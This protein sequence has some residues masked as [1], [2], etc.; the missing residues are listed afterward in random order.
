MA[1]AVYICHTHSLVELGVFGTIR[2]RNLQTDSLFKFG[3]HH[4]LFWRWVLKIKLAVKYWSE[5]LEEGPAV[6]TKYCYT[7][8]RLNGNEE[9]CG[10]EYL[11]HDETLSDLNKPVC[12]KPNIFWPWWF[13]QW[14]KDNMQRKSQNSKFEVLKFNSPTSWND[15]HTSMSCWRESYHEAADCLL[16]IFPKAFIFTH[17][18]LKITQWL[19]SVQKTI[20]CLHR[21]PPTW[22]TR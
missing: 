13:E 11:P 17:E 3:F 18:P 15:G 7:S 22:T 20:F 8:L 6:I 12:R 9:S 4:I 5:Y 10:V 19:K 14:E 2:V 21:Q 16:V 1:T